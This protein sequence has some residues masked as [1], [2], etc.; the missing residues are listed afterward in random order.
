MEKFK[1]LYSQSNNKDTSFLY[2]LALTK[3]KSRGWYPREWNLTDYEKHLF[4]IK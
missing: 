2:E 3:G 4:K 1:Y